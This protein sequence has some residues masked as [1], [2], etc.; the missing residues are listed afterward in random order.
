M[1]LSFQRVASSGSV[2]AVADL[3]VP[4]K[5]TQAE[6]QADTQPIRYTMDGTDPASGSGMLFLTTADPKLFNIEDVKKIKFIQ[7]AGGAGGLNV[8]YLAGRD[9]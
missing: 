3:T 8:H 5:A 4:A 9:I 1:Y 2:K 6:I 7:G